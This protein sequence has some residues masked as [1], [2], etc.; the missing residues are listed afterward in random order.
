MKQLISSVKIQQ[1]VFGQGNPNFDIYNVQGSVVYRAVCQTTQNF[2]L[3][4]YK[5]S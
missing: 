3:L 1:A 2:Q 5:V 4:E